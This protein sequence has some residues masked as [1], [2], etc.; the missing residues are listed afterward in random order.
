MKIISI[1]SICSCLLFTGCKDFLKVDPPKNVEVPETIFSTNETANSAVLTIYGQMSSS[2]VTTPY[3]LSYLTG[4]SADELKNNSSITDDIYI[5]AIDP[6]SSKTNEFWSGT[7]SVIYAANAVYEGVTKSAQL[8]ANLKK[9]LLGEASFIRAYWYFNLVNLYGDVPIVL[10]TDYSN[11][12]S[13]ARKPVQDVYQQ[14][15]NDLKFAQD[16]LNEIN[17]GQDGLSPANDRIRPNKDVATALLAKVY[18]YTGDN[19]SAEEL[20]TTLISNGKYLL[21]PLDKVFLKDSK[22][23]I[24]QIMPVDRSD[25]NTEEGLNYIPT[26]VPTLEGKYTISDQLFNAFETADKRKTSWIGTYTDTEPTPNVDYHYPYKYKVQFGSNFTEYSVIFRL[27]EQYLIRAEA[28]IILGNLTG[29]A[30]DINV[31]RNRAGLD[32]S[33]AS[34]PNELMAAVMHERNAEFFTEQGHRWFDLKR[35]KNVNVVMPP[36]TTLKGGGWNKDKQLW[37]I[38]YSEI[39]KAPNLR[40][41]TGY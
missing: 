33:S 6:R 28:R 41:N 4:I 37:P 23:A 2:T 17:V 24:W 29:A 13:M 34:T 36:I 8:S 26:T 10:S 35:T 11:N 18:L 9:Q 14:I 38:P 27:A 20:A 7:Y 25:F 31:I 19:K 3:S 5:N 39:L 22:E 40:Q 21:E 1:I 12:A 30:Q 16:N 15:I 32:K